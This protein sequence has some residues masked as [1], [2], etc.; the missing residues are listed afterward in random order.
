MNSP[1][2]VPQRCP[3]PS[4]KTHTV[5]VDLDGDAFIMELPVSMKTVAL[6]GL[7]DK[8]FDGVYRFRQWEVVRRSKEVI[9]A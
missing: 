7:F 5:A 9:H 3:N 1:H 2:P 8:G 4:G 6:T